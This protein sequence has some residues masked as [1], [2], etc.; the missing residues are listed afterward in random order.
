MWVEEGIS[1]ARSHSPSVQEGQLKFT[2]SKILFGHFCEDENPD[3]SEQVNK[4]AD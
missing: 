4:F 2:K 1:M 3:S